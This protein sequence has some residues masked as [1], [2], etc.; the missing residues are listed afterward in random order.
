MRK[1]YEIGRRILLDFEVPSII[2]EK[3]NKRDF[4]TEFFFL[5]LRPS[6]FPH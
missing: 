1:N 2:I 6:F 5:D 4:Y 3:E